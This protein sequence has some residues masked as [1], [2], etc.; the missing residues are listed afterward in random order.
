M[1]NILYSSRKKVFVGSRILLNL[2]FPEWFTVY[3]HIA[4]AE[5]SNKK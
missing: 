3:I 2:H 1:A 5:N 4:H